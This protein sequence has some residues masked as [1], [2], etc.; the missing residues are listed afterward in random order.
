M[1]ISALRLRWFFAAVFAF[2]LSVGTSF[3]LSSQITTLTNAD[4]TKLDAALTNGGLI[5]F[6]SSFDFPLTRTKIITNDVI[7]DGKITNVVSKTNFV[8]V[9]NVIVDTNL[10]TTNFTITTNVSSVDSTTN[11]LTLGN[12]VRFSGTDTRLFIIATNVTAIFDHIVLSNGVAN[13]G[14]AIS[15]A[16][17]L[18]CTNVYFASNKAKGRDGRAGNGSDPNGGAGQNGLGGALFNT[19]RTILSRCYFE[20]NSAIGGTGGDGQN[21]APDSLFGK[22]G[23]NGGN[24]GFGIGG[25][26][27]NSR[28]SVTVMETVFNQNSAAGGDGG[29][30]GVGGN[31]PFPGKPGDAGFGGPSYGGAIYNYALLTNLQCLFVENTVDGGFGMPQ[32]SLKNGPSGGAAFGGAIMNVK[33]NVMVN[34]TVTSNL[35]VGGQGGGAQAGTLIYGGRGGSAGGGSIYNNGGK[36]LL[37]SCTFAGGTVSNGLG[38][39]SLSGDPKH[40]GAPGLA[41]GGN[42]CVALGAM[43]LTNCIIAYGF[44]TNAF[45][46]LTK[47]SYNLSSDRS[48]VFSGGVTNIPRAGVPPSDPLL[49]PLADHGG[50]TFTMGLGIGSKALSG[51]PNGAATNLVSGI[52]QRGTNRIA[53]YEIGAFEATGPFTVS[54]RLTFGTNRALTNATIT[55]EGALTNLTVTNDLEGNYSFVLP[56]GVFTI[57]PH[58]SLTNFAFKPAST[59]LEVTSDLVLPFKI[60]ALTVKGTV[61]N[62]AGTGLSGVNIVTT[63][64]FYNQSFSITSGVKGVFILTDMAPGTNIVSANSTNAVFIPASTNITKSVSN[65]NFVRIPT[66]TVSGFI[67]N[68]AG[69]TAFEQSGI[70]L[71]LT[72]TAANTSTTNALTNASGY[73]GR[74]TFSNVISG[75]YTLSGGTSNV[76][77]TPFSVQVTSNITRLKVIGTLQ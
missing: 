1:I 40:N 64:P 54:G 52:D 11:L 60:D 70:P 3:G 49:Q 56:R 76:T 51:G 25:A 36:S 43:N 71:V 45:G 55:V 35:C 6:S 13:M 23:G 9:T 67:T 30:A 5:L 2:C 32:F 14:G 65:V 20:R 73:I 62:K 16:G 58:Y 44:P 72:P 28:G 53:P 34:S 74:F 69:A 75:P 22:P 26:I 15:N 19:G 8:L 63:N 17:T 37:T 77:F 31:A 12:M 59:N 24:G 38:G 41:R 7:F 10:N 33:T 47:S 46:P 50:I 42:L 48:T 66:F 18:I 4:E 27:Y 68:K 57:T 29:L 21:G 61:K 39:I